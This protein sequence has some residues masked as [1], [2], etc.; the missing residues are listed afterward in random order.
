MH[1]SQDVSL[2][3][4]IGTDIFQPLLEPTSTQVSRQLLPIN[5]PQDDS[6]LPLIGTDIFEL[7]L[8][9]SPVSGQLCPCIR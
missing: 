9:P 6:L 2:L 4:L 3:P 8:E 5:T 1:S 7:L